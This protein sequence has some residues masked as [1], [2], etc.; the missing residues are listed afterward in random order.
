MKKILLFLFTLCIFQVSAQDISSLKNSATTSS[1]SM[2][3]NLAVDQVKSLTKKLNLNETQQAQVSDL[4][5][6]QLKSD[7]FQKLIG[8]MGTDKL[9][10]SNSSNTDKLQNALIADKDFQKDLK[11]VLDEEQTKKLNESIKY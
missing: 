11:S 9:L 8:S 1:S 5:I 10:S 7:K 4:V 2:I 6:G 3:E